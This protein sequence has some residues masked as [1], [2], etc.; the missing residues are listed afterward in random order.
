MDY[1][2]PFTTGANSTADFVSDSDAPVSN[3]VVLVTVPSG[4]V[5]SVVTQLVRAA[6]TIAKAISMY[7]NFIGVFVLLGRDSRANARSKSH[8]QEKDAGDGHKDE[9]P[10]EA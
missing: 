10:H 5:V 2:V 8:E 7:L 4:A 1:F 6:V 3:F 9:Q